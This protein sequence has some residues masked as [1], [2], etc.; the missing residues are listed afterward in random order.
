MYSEIFTPANQGIYHSLWE[1][2][3]QINDLL[4]S[5]GVQEIVIVLQFFLLHFLKK[6]P[7]S[8]NISYHDQWL[9]SVQ[10]M[11]NLLLDSFLYNNDKFRTRKFKV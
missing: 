5:N 8:W 10:R 9:Q 11:I 4:D 2:E 7:F 6:F 3:S 1:I